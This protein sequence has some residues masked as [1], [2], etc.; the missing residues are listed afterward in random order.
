MDSATTVLENC[1]VWADRFYME[2]FD[3]LCVEPEVLNDRQAWWCAINRLPIESIA[4]FVRATGQ[5]NLVAFDLKAKLSCAQQAFDTYKQAAGEFESA[6]QEL[7]LS[8]SAY[9]KEFLSGVAYVLA[10]V[11]V[12]LNKIAFVLQLVEQ[13]RYDFERAEKEYTSCCS[14]SRCES[15]GCPCCCN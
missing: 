15:N 8:D 5:H 4:S 7:G 10:T 14:E 1:K 13:R 3:Q 9:Y 6:W 11:P 2:P 12:Y